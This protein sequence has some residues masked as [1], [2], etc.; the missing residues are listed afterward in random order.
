MRKKR[1]NIEKRRRQKMN[2]RWN[3]VKRMEKRKS[4][5]G[6]RSGKT[7]EGWWEEWKNKKRVV[8]GVG[9]C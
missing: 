4:R 3:K 8:G 2:K 9:R 6:G 7:R 5:M 1:K